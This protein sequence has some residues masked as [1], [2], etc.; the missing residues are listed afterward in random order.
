VEVG[1]NEASYEKREGRDYVSRFC[2]R[3]TIQTRRVTVI[4]G[5][6]DGETCILYTA[7]GGPLAPKEPGD[8]SLKDEEREESLR[9][10]KTH[11]LSR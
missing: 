5:P 8:S 6:H 2:Q 1:E 3:A 7:F 10:W 4:A 11:A 9:F